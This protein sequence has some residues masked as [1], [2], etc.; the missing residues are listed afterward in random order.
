MVSIGTG[1]CSFN[2]L[3]ACMRD[4]QSASEQRR[5]DY[6]ERTNHI[7]LER[8]QI[9]SAF[10]V[11]NRVVADRPLE[12]LSDSDCIEILEKFHQNVHLSIKEELDRV[13]FKTVSGCSVYRSRAKDKITV[14]LE[15]FSASPLSRPKDPPSIYSVSEARKYITW[16][17]SLKLRQTGVVRLNRIFSNLISTQ[18]DDSNLNLTNRDYR[19]IL[20]D[21]YSS[22][23][24]DP[25]LKA[26]LRQ[27]GF[28]PISDYSLYSDSRAK[29]KVIAL[30]EFLKE[31]SKPRD[32]REHKN[33]HNG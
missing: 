26:H 18:Q 31:A 5:K 24:V 12:S 25:K 21:F 13:G 6:S 10:D 8:H 2:P 11:L 1:R 19:E 17:K 14:L 33:E 23:A 15:F 28:K 20:K 22:S 16:T 27:K 30:R 3:S 4:Q 32:I 7:Y 9:D 29:F